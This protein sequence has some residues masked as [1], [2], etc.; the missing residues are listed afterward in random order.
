MTGK[1]EKRRSGKRI[2]ALILGGVLFLV[3]LPVTAI[4]VSQLV[5][6]WW[7]FPNF[8]TI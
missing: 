3:V 4:Y 6:S 5:D 1:K 8:P 7:G 2:A